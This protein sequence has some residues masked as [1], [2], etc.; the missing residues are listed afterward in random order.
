MTSLLAAY[1]AAL[2]LWFTAIVWGPFR[3]DLVFGEAHHIYY[4]L[5]LGLVGA[6]SGAWWFHVLGLALC[7]DDALQHAIQRWGN[8][9]YRSPVHHLTTLVYL[10]PFVQRLNAWLDRVL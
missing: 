3:D 9:A 4:G 6:L 2:V 8:P 7:W 5:V 10:L 1:V